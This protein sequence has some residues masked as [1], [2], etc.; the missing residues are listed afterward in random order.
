L[1]IFGLSVVPASTRPVTSVGHNFE[2]LIIFMLTGTAFGLGYTRHIG[3]L[4][5]AMPVF[6]GGIELVQLVAPGRHARLVDFIVD[7]VAALAGVVVAYLV[8]CLAP[9]TKMT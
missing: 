1:A 8:A 4:L 9:R 5:L 3:A 6:A 7:A 2:H